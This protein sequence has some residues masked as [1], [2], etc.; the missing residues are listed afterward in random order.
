MLPPILKLS[1]ENSNFFMYNSD[2]LTSF[3]KNKWLTARFYSRICTLSRRSLYP[4]STQNVEVA[5]S[6]AALNGRLVTKYIDPKVDLYK[7]KEPF[8]QTMVLTFQHEI[9]IKG[10]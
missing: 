2:F 9:N 7:E 1:M 3:K 8:A 4:A 6:H 5:D 10:L